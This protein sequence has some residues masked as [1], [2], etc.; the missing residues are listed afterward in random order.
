MIALLA[1][2]QH[3]PELVQAA[4]TWIVNRLTLVLVLP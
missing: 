4:G 3:L 1:G 2:T